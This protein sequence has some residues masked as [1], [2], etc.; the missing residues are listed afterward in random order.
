M[1]RLPL[2]TVGNPFN[3]SD[4]LARLSAHNTTKSISSP[5]ETRI[6][7]LRVKDFRLTQGQVRFRDHPTGARLAY[8]DIG[9]H[10]RQLDTQ[11]L[12]NQQA[13]RYTIR[14]SS[15]DRGQLR[16]TGQFQL[17]P[18]A[19]KGKLSLDAF[20]LPPFWPFAARM[21]PARLTHGT[22]DLHADYQLRE[23]DHQL[24]Y[25]MQ[26]G[27]FTLSGLVFQDRD[28]PKV[29]LAML[30]LNDIAVQSTKRRIDVGQL[31]LKGLWADAVFNHQGVDLVRLF[32]PVA[33]SEST[34]GM[35]A[36]TAH[37]TAS[38]SPVSSSTPSAKSPPWEVRIRQV[39]M[40]QTDLNLTEQR[41]STGVHWRIS[42]FSVSTDSIDSR[43]SQP[44]QYQASLDIAAHSRQ[45]PQQSGGH[46]STQGTVDVKAQRTQG[47]I[48]LN[49]LNL[50]QFQPYLTP[51]VNLQL[52]Q[53]KLSTTGH[54]R[55]A[56][57]NN[58]VTYQGQADLTQLSLKDTLYHQP[59]LKWQAMHIK[60]IQ[61]DQQAHRLTMHVINLDQPY[62]KILI[63]KDR[64]TNI[65]HLLATPSPTTTKAMPGSA[66]SQQ[67]APQKLSSRQTKVSPQQTSSR[68]K[69]LRITIGTIAFKNGSAYFADDSLTPGF[70][71]GIESL[72]GAIRGL[73][74]VPNT[75]ATVDLK[76]KI[77]RYA[78]VTVSG[79]MN[80]FVTPPSLDLNVGFHGVEL[81]TINPYSG[82][83]AGYYID[84]GQLSMDLQYQLQQNHLL[85]KNHIVIDQL[86]LGKATHSKQ[87]LDL[88][89]KLAIALLQDRHGVINLGLDVSGDLAQP[90]FSLS[91]ILGTAISNMF[92]K[93]ITAPFS[94]LE[95]LFGDDAQKNVVSFEAGIA[96]LGPA[97]KKQ[98]Q[99]L[100]KALNNRPKL[101]L[102]VRASIARAQDIQA[103]KNIKLKQALL[104]KSGLKALPVDLTAS[105]FPQQGAL[106]DALADLFESELK[107]D[108][109]KVRQKIE[110]LLQN[111]QSTSRND[112][113]EQSFDQKMITTRLHIAM[114]N[115]LLNAQKVSEGELSHLAENRALQVKTY[116]TNQGHLAPERI[117]ILKSKIDG[118][119]SNVI[120]TLDTD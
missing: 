79:K 70:A 21:I 52:S 28:T 67:A 81:T 92:S 105:N 99:T 49:D 100:A 101:T 18:L 40:T 61:F 109:E 102:T 86:Q 4:I 7:A 9:I 97:E 41:I 15:S 72:E 95:S 45:R 27:Q 78:P 10:L 63:A 11:A 112:H 71:S 3:F 5:G 55:Y 30:H 116:L 83:Y 90:N 53:G 37:Q 111:E 33:T 8:D 62:M 23:Q 80:P 14:L 35:G 66:A 93:V 87:A 84:K 20:T 115:Q 46:L 94:L 74:S 60:D 117:F 107:L 58:D 36:S 65:G 64:S 34:N 22:I 31:K 38:S 89:L 57:E 17:Q 50:S 2:K 39:K 43:F 91:G 26:K 13:N 119:G 114:Y 85:G 19:V 106:T 42:D 104:V 103:L 75:A 88:P 68:K 12:L 47:E 16:L 73:S 32:T 98:L 108:P 69:A 56:W 1:V 76:G 96:T 48:A 120:L 110:R 82:T 6:P 118:S 59:L 113:P 44:I 51:Y 25:Q 24:V 29:R 77:D 54:F